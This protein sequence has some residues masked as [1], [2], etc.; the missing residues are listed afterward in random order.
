[1]SGC[2]MSDFLAGLKIR[3]FKAITGWC[4]SGFYLIC[5]WEQ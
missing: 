3:C 4:L 5:H 2:I 1:M